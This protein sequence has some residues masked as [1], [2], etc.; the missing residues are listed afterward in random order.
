M[1]LV[2]RLLPGL[3]GVRGVANQPTQPHTITWAICP[4][5]D[6]DLELSVW[7]LN[8]KHHQ[9][10]KVLKNRDMYYILQ[11]VSLII[12]SHPAVHV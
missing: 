6:D 9:T 5:A 1:L 4:A 7:L 8:T 2:L 12:L 10:S 11:L 3:D